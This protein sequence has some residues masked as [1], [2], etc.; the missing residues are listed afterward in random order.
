MNNLPRFRT[1]QARA[2]MALTLAMDPTM[3][4]QLDIFIR[5]LKVRDIRPDYM[6][7]RVPGADRCESLDDPSA[8]NGVVVLPSGAR[9]S[10][11]LIRFPDG[12][13]SIHS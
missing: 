2:F 7:R 9:M 10:C 11:S 12:K 5:Q 8:W 6:L 4:E 13:W 3:K 1:P